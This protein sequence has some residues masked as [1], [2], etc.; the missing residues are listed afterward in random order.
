MVMFLYIIMCII[1][2]TTFLAIK[3]GVD[4][5][6]P[7]FMSA[8]IR[9]FLAG[10]ILYL[11]MKIQ[12][13]TTIRFL[14]RKDMFLSGLGLTFGTFA[15][16]YWAE[17]HVSSGIAAVLSATGPMMIMAIQGFF[18]RENMNHRSIVGGLIGFSGVFLLLFSSISFEASLLW[19][20]GCIV[21]LIGEVSYASGTL[22]SKKIIEFH[23]GTS[24]IVLN[25]AQMIYGGGSLI[26][27]SLFTERIDIES[28]LSVPA[29]GS[30]F[31]LMLVGS[32]GGHTIYYWLISKTN[33]N[34]PS[35]WLYISP[36]IAMVV[37][38]LFYNEPIT[39]VMGMGVLTILI[40]TIIMN[41][42]VLP[43]KKRVTT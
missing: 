12:R 38:A 13:K 3:I 30:L 41:F 6:A 29:M 10:V 20:V 14:F 17:Q 26:L 23:K 1:F 9:F 42:D 15:T 7:P 31:Y 25:A 34:F 16:L 33:P 40:G 43:R 36:L 22:Y 2:G 18:L 24:P 4:G 27:L 21:I 39:W 19:L 11:V 37:G 8:G 35:T 5:G 28:L 32:M